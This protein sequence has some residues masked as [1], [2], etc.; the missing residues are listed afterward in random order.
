MKKSLWF[1]LIFVGLV[2]SKTSSEYYG[3]AAFLYIENRLPSAE[4]LCEE[5]LSKYP[6]DQKLQMLLD[7]IREAKDEQK[8]ENQKNTIFTVITA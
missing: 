7:R 4:I 6:Q 2:F 3:E 5:G 8:K 1:I